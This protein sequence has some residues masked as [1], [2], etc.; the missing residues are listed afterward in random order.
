MH[1]YAE[2][3][4]IPPQGVIPPHLGTTAIGEIVEIPSNVVETAVDDVFDNLRKNNNDVLDG[5]QC[6]KYSYNIAK[7]ERY[8]WPNMYNEIHAYILKCG[9]CQKNQLSL[10]SPIVPLQPLPIITKD[11]VVFVRILTR[12]I[13]D[14]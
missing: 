4:Q 1:K 13:I 2:K 9:P 5:H 6:F 12:T 14:F 3:Y 8:Y 11:T 7:K 10:K